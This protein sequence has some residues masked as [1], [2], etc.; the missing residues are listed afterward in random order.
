MVYSV[1]GVLYVQCVLHVMPLTMSIFLDFYTITARSKC[2]VLS[3]GVLCS[4]LI[5][6]FP[7]MSRRYLTND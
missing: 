7:G 1:A 3:T 5:S 4:P 2:T 6:C